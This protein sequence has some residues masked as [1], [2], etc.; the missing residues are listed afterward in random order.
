MENEY[1]FRLIPVNKVPPKSQEEI[2]E[3]LNEF[4]QQS[5][6]N[7]LYFHREELEQIKKGEKPKLSAKEKKHLIEMGIL[8]YNKRNKE[9]FKL[10]LRTEKTLKSIREL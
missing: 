9:R 2:D 4:E 7:L 6:E 5:F 1:K 3:T 8:T 10:S